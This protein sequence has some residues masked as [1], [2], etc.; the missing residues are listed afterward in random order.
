[1]RM[2][3]KRYHL[4]IVDYDLIYRHFKEGAFAVSIGFSRVV[5]ADIKLK[6]NI[7][8]SKKDLV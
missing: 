7:K 2:L 5:G 8:R 4:I 6:Q 3:V 1:M